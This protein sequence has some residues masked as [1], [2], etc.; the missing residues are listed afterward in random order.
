[1]SSRHSGNSFGSS[2]NNNTMRPLEAETYEASRARQSIQSQPDK[3]HYD[4]GVS[5]RDSPYRQL[6]HQGGLMG[7][8]RIRLVEAADLKRSY[9]S[10]LAL[11]PVKHLNWSKAHGPVSSYCTFSLQCV[12]IHADRLQRNNNNNDRK[13][14]AAA[15]STFRGSIVSPM[16]TRDDNPVWDHCQFEFPLR[17][18]ALPTDGQRVR[19]QIR[20][21]EDS[22][23]LENIL[24]G[25]P[26]GGDSRLLGIGHLDVTDLLLG[27]DA[28][29]CLALPTVVDEWVSISLQGKTMPEEV[30]EFLYHK[31]DPLKPP[32]KPSAAATNVEPPKETG[33]VRVLV[34]YE[35]HGMEPRP[36][37]VVALEA[38]ARRYGNTSSCRPVIPPL[39]PYTVL[40]RRGL[41]LLCRYTA[42]DG[43]AACV[44]LHRNAV[45]VIERQSLVDAAHNLALLPADV[46]MSTP[47][48]RAVGNATSPLVEAG[49]QLMMP[50]LLSFKLVWMACR[51][52]TLAGFSGVQA[53]GSTLWNEGTQAL[54]TSS[55][56]ASSRNNS[57]Y[58]RSDSSSHRHSAAAAKFVSL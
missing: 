50:A 34:S 45:F 5:F 9:W 35:P 26:T 25:V 46:W 30:Q 42:A 17:K 37:D 14:A 31:E 4:T 6:H 19:L 8:L 40:E 36:K 53:L 18:G 38:F 43:K 29:T 20:V 11:G 13:P 32:S 10:A 28:F 52:T 57:E 51:T 44:R 23:A 1:M 48:G 39:A 41:F 27:Q 7:R 21:D 15:T 56:S 24:P 3:I 22:T 16:I 58:A 54:T 49:A 33:R 2:S 12:D 47:L 55:S